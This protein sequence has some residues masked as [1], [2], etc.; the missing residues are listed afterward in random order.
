M[1]CQSH[2]CAF[3]GDSNII[4]SV[5]GWC[6]ISVFAVKR[7]FWFTWVCINQCSS[8]SCE[9]ANC[10]LC[11][12]NKKDANKKNS[13]LILRDAGA[14]LCF[15]HISLLMLVASIFSSRDLSI[16]SIVVISKYAIV[17]SP[18]ILYAIC[19]TLPIFTD[20]VNGCIDLFV[21]IFSFC[22]CVWVGIDIIR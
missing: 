2:K 20:K 17:T 4:W 14:E 5:F 8:V 13:L 3:S 22:V 11:I 6:L 9:A 16:W 7:L 21:K 15:I 12:M 1:Q 18:N 10:A 19:F